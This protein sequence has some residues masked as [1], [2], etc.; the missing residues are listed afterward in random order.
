[1]VVDITALTLDMSNAGKATFNTDINV[2]YYTDAKAEIQ[3]Q[4][5]FLMKLH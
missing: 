1:M 4:Q 3:L 2:N 5:L